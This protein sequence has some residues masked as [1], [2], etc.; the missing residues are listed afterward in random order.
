MKIKKSRPT[1]K[2]PAWS[3]YDRSH[4]KTVYDVNRD[5]TPGFTADLKI[6]NAP[7]F[8]S[9]Y[10]PNHEYSSLNIFFEHSSKPFTN[11]HIQVLGVRF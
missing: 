3:F 4:E 6:E 8:S 2:P 1:R 10:L 7:L 9:L 5:C 11:H